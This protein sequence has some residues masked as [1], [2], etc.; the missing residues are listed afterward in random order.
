[1]SI[2][3]SKQELMRIIKEELSL[4]DEE[5][6]RKPSLNDAITA[7]ATVAHVLMELQN[8]V[9]ESPY[10]G[11]LIAMAAEHTD[12]MQGF[13]DALASAKTFR[14]AAGHSHGGEDTKA[15]QMTQRQGNPITGR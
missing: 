8:L 10:A 9:T 3:I 6:A 15:D 5:Q 2:D 12:V 1:M 11:E 4:I 7:V 13:V 14:G